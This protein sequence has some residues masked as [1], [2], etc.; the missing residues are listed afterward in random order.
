MMRDRGVHHLLLVDRGRI[1]AIVS[2]RNLDHA[3]SPWAEGTAAT[4][5]DDETLR[6]PVYSCATYAMQTIRHDAPIEEAAAILLEEDISALPVLGADG[7]IAGIV[8]ARD[9]LRELLAC[10]I[11]QWPHAGRCVGG[12]AQSAT[13]RPPDSRESCNHPPDALLLGRTGGVGRMPSATNEPALSRRVPGPP[14]S[15]RR[16]ASLWQRWEQHVAPELTVSRTA[17]E[18]VRQPT[19]THAQQRQPGAIRKCSSLSERRRPPFV[20]GG[21]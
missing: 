16:R 14:P 13:P 6:R 9:L 15:R 17:T 3:L 10:H 4:R 2:D 18:S 19:E 21:E 5:R 7:D 11:E 1:V 12:T 20:S 8:T